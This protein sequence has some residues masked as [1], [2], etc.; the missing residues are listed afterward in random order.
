[1]VDKKKPKY[2]VP[3]SGDVVWVDLNPARGHE[4]HGAR[5][6]LVLTSSAYNEASGLC[7]MVPITSVAKGY[8]FEI[9]V[10]AKKITGSALVDQVRCIDWKT[11]GI[12]HC[13]IVD[14]STLR[15]IKKLLSQL[16]LLEK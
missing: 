11:R 4:Q 16:L 8:P 12:K 3:N 15:A 10:K 5:P 6:A 2:T 14:T 7:L 1:M 9:A 13:D